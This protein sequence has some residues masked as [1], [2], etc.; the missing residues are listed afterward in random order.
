MPGYLQYWLN[1]LLW[2]VALMSGILSIAR[3][4]LSIFFPGQ[5][6]QRSLFW[7]CVVIACIISV[8]LLWWLEHIKAINFSKELE[9]EKSDKEPKLNAEFSVLATSPV[10]E[11]DESSVI[12][13][14]A[15]ITNIG[16]PSIISN[17]QVVIKKGNVEIQG[18]DLVLGQ[19]PM[20]LE[21]EGK[22]L[23]LLLK[24]EDNLVKKGISSPIP[25]GGALHGWH[26]VLAENIQKQEVYNQNVII[27]F[28][29][30]DV[31][32]KSY[33]VEKRMDKAVSK[34]IDA[35]KL[36]KVEH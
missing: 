33:A 6:P 35:T 1:V 22:D 5:V 36:Q 34:L 7:N 29:Y 18:K 32:G 21:G 9:K 8:S 31:T 12:I 27:I 25:T 23:K 14:T 20:F 15:I 11:H 30:Q 17:V 19:G 13:I 4:V 28:T 16:A 24:E 26:I 2:G 10:G 3:E